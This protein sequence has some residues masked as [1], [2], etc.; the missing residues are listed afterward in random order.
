MADKEDYYQMLGLQ[1]L[2][3]R[4]SP[5]VYLTPETLL[6]ETRNPKLG[7]QRSD[8]RGS[9]LPIMLCASLLFQPTRLPSTYCCQVASI[10]VAGN[11]EGV[12]AVRVCVRCV[13]DVSSLSLR[14]PIMLCFSLLC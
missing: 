7:S 13:A 14:L 10:Y 3:W 5:Q 1:S 4:A 2:R 8:W 11:P 12:P 9:G 6:P